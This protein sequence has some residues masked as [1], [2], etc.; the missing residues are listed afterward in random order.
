MIK[1]KKLT[2]Q[3]IN[4]FKLNNLDFKKLDHKKF[5]SSKIIKILPEKNSLFETVLVAANDE[6]VK[7][8][9]KNKINYSDISNKIIKILSI[10]E[11]KKLKKFFQQKYL[12]L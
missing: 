9:L 11:F 6:L 5:S 7:L 1:K 3:H 10:N 8:F 12:T 4:F 2:S